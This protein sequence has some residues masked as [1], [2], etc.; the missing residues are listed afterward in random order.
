MENYLIVHP[1]VAKVKKTIT[2][3]SLFQPGSRLLV[4]VSG[5]ADSVALVYVVHDLAC[6]WGLHLRL[7]HVNHSL[8]GAESDADE[9][10]VKTLAT[11]L[12]L[13][14]ICERL[15]LQASKRCRD[16]SLEDRCRQERY[17]CYLKYARRYR[18]DGIVLAHHK[19]DLA[20]TMLMRMLRGAG[21]HGLHGF[22]PKSSYQG[23]MILRPFYNVTR[24]EIQDFLE[25]K[26]ICWRED[27][28]NRDM[29]FLRN[30]VRIKLIPLLQ[31]EFNPAI[32][33]T[34]A[35]MAHIMRIEDQYLEFQAKL[36]FE[37]HVMR[38]SKDVLCFPAK[39]FHSVDPALSQ[40][41]LRLA[42]IE[43]SGQPYGPEHTHVETLS[44]AILANETGQLLKCSHNILVYV[45]YYHVIFARITVARET[46]KQALLCRLFD[47]L[48]KNMLLETVQPLLSLRTQTITV[49]R[50]AFHRLNKHVVHHLNGWQISL[51]RVR[52][53]S[54]LLK[55]VSRQANAAPLIQYYDMDGIHFPLLI[56]SR[57]DGDR[58]QPFGSTGTQRLKQFFINMKIPLYLRDHIPLLCDKRQILW[59]MGVRRGNA[60]RIGPASKQLL[61]IELSRFK[62][63]RV[64]K[65]KR[66]KD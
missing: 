65:R 61:R 13:P 62:E 28:S 2:F 4:G 19:D 38:G 50:S 51:K 25:S 15:K 20:E 32:V 34:L 54:S 63:K 60:G 55:R 64:W 59:I 7:L 52:N 8:R 10:F 30:K 17:R 48:K 27:S 43:I 16:T 29:R 6:N 1:F 39:V 41:L 56:R 12:S 24:H 44:K 26:S 3:H 33:D 36:V 42:Y 53:T 11:K 23:V 5:G 57:R 47:L 45:S 40:R 9:R 58:F 35:R 18:V 66:S 31:K 14:V 49:S 21:I 37:Q 46:H 22:L